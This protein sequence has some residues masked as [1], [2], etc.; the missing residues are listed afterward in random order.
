MVDHRVVEGEESAST[1][2][3]VASARVVHLIEVG[4]LGESLSRTSVVGMLEPS[5][6]DTSKGMMDPGKVLVSASDVLVAVAI[7][8]LGGSTG[9]EG[10]RSRSAR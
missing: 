1:L 4:A 9:K 3:V 7:G 6:L 8:E 2:L 10:I 5:R